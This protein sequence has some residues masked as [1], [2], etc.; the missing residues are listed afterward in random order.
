MCAIFQKRAKKGQNIWKFGQKC[1]KFENILKKGTQSTARIGL[2]VY[3]TIVM[4]H[5]QIYSVHISRKCICKTG[6]ITENRSFYYSQ[7]KL[8]LLS[9]SPSTRQRQITHSPRLSGWTMKTY[10]KMY[11]FKSTLTPKTLY[12]FSTVS[13]YIISFR[14]L[15]PAD[16]KSFH[17]SKIISYYSMNIK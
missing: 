10:F 3:S 1:T 2:P 4:K 9:L 5:I 15:V 12:I 7:A 13:I 6:K 14:L 17:V 11:C 8:S 16:F